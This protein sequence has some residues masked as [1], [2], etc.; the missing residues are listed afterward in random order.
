MERKFVKTEDGSYTLY[1]PEL[2][3]HYHS[4]HGAI[5]E[6]EHIFINSGLLQIQKRSVRI[7]EYGLGSGLN[8]LLSIKEAIDKGLNIYYE[9]VEKYPLSSAEWGILSPLLKESGFEN[10]WIDWVANSPWNEEALLCDRI[11]LRKTTTD[12]RLH[13]PE[14]EFDVIY[15]DAFAPEVQ[16]KLWTKEIFL[17][18]FQHTALNGRLVTYS[19]KGEVR[20]NLTAAGYQVNKLPGPPGKREISCGCKIFS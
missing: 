6:S 2:H 16:P 17:K 5:T 19:A 11:V 15:Y 8:L 7:L 12:F 13:Q 3:E 4:I 1:V 9:A 20:R 10:Q 18:L 14:G